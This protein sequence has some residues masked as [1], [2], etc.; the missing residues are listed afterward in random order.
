MGLSPT[1]PIDPG[2]DA[3]PQ[4]HALHRLQPGQIGL[5]QPDADSFALA[6]LH[7]SVRIEQ[8]TQESPVKITGGTFHGRGDALVPRRHAQLPGE[9]FQG[10]Q[11][12]PVLVAAID[13]VPAEE[14][15]PVR[16]GPGSQ[17]GFLHDC[18]HPRRQNGIHTVGGCGRFPDREHRLVLLQRAVAHQQSEKITLF[19]GIVSCPGC[20]HPMIMQQHP[21]ASPEPARLTPFAFRRV[22]AEAG[23]PPHPVIRRQA[24]P[25]PF[26]RRQFD[27]PLGGCA[28]KPLLPTGVV[29]TIHQYL[30]GCTD[31]LPDLART[32][33]GLYPG[34]RRDA[35]IGRADVFAE[36][37]VVHV[38]DSVDED[39][40]RFGVVIGGRHD[41][42][43]QSPRG[44]DP[45][46][47]AGDQSFAVDDVTVFV[48]EFPPDDLLAIIE[49]QLF[50]LQ[51]RL[52][53]GKSQRPFPVML[54][55][56]HEF[57][58]NQ[59]RQIKLP[60]AAVFPFRAN[61][62]DDVRVADIEG[63]HLRAA[64]AAGRG[65]REAHPVIDVHEGQRPGG[66]GAG[67]RD[68]GALGTQ[69][70]KLVAYAAA[71]LQRETGF[72]HLVEY[73]IHGIGDHARN[74]AIDRRC[75]RFVL[76]RSGIGND[77]SGRYRAL[78]QRP[79]KLLVI[80]FLVGLAGLHVGQCP[81]DPFVSGVDRIVD[82]FVMLGLQAIFAVPDLHGGFLQRYIGYRIADHL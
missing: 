26:R 1:I 40:A 37:V 81:G 57:T 77:A 36:P 17:Q 67:A 74:G 33:A 3:Q 28:K 78:P 71:R 21:V 54:D 41:D 11:R 43:P 73:V 61:E 49:V 15:R 35:G 75:R 79:E 20:R 32:F 52:G 23:N 25:V 70:G 2:V 56:F 47:F 24:Q 76:P 27:H 45:A 6:P 46:D 50:A 16:Q 22:A 66:I 10:A 62:F 14:I 44:N 53:N 5:G 4:Q 72:V 51:L 68:I 31:Q 55:G 63:G 60:Q 59:Q 65:N 82:D 19:L 64:S 12:E 8:P 39:E 29:L 18:F 48:G 38:I 9:I 30:E 58:G 80:A 69:R 13:R 34:I 7:R 42:I